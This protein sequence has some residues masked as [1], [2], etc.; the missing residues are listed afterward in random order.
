[1][2]E[3]RAEGLCKRFLRGKREVKV[4]QDASLC[5]GRGEL[6]FLT[7]ESGS[8]KTTLLKI[9]A[10]LL[11]PDDGRVLV[12]GRDSAAFTEDE[13]CDLRQRVVS[14]LPQ[15]LGL[16]EALTAVQNVALPAMFSGDKAQCKELYSRATALLDRTGALALRDACPAE[17]SGG[18][19]KRVLLA[20]ALMTAP[21]FLLADEPTADL[22]RE[23][24][25]DF[26][27]LFAALWAQGTG[28]LVVT[29]DWSQLRA[30]DRVLQLRDGEVRDVTEEIGTSG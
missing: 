5:L 2:E 6:V 24:A 18:E 22:D 23:S 19:T 21:R 20:R 11:K 13:C 28:V 29:H 26:L 1:M 3:L 9:L 7:G 14:Y 10:G 30:A 17:L 12:N 8:G 4:L 25:A 27:R 16:L 15:Q